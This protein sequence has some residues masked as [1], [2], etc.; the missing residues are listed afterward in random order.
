MIVVYTF[1]IWV[2][3]MSLLLE[4][5]YSFIKKHTLLFVRWFFSCI[6]PL[7]V[8]FS[9][10][11]V[12]F[13]LDTSITPF[14]DPIHPWWADWLWVVWLNDA[15]P[16]TW[17]QEDSLVNV[18]TWVVNR[19]LW[20]LSLIALLVVLRWWFQM[21]IAAW[22]EDKYNKWFTILKQASVWL[23]MIWLARFLVSGIFW[24]I[25]LVTTE[26]KDTWWSTIG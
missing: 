26:A 4:S 1:D 2:F 8:L 10:W 15:T 18:I 3:S 16:T 9:L 5:K 12:A 17:G 19:V 11:W 25:S 24:L 22:D 6:V 23:A 20:V 14:T 13:G 21:V 7:V